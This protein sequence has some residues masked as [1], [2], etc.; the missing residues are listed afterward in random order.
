MA[1]QDLGAGRV[2][3]LFGDWLVDHRVRISCGL[4]FAALLLSL[5]GKDRPRDVADY[6]DLW[7]LAG[8]LP[9]VCGLG[10]RS[11][12]AGVLRKGRE[13]ATTGPYRLCRHPLYLGTLLMM[14]GFLLL[15]PDIKH[16][17]I[18]LVPVLILYRVTIRR[19]ERRMVKK[20]GVA[21]KNYAARTP[22]LFPVRWP[23]PLEGKWSLAQ[24]LRSREYNPVLITLLILVLLKLWN[25]CLSG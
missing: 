21:W 10:L 22:R 13:L 20:Y 6:R 19:E 11:W 9:V 3:P 23:K 14:A 4:F 18:I 2:F 7:V 17:L 15:F 8:I 25:D 16:V 1:S 12:A 5:V 24:W